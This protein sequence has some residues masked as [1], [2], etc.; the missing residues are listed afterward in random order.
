MLL[1]RMCSIFHEVHYT[2]KH[3]TEQLVIIPIQRAIHELFPPVRGTC[4][5]WTL[6][7][8]GWKSLLI[9][10]PL[11]HT[12]I[13]RLNKLIVNIYCA[14]TVGI[15]H[16]HIHSNVSGEGYV[17]SVIQWGGWLNYQSSWSTKWSNDWFE[18]LHIITLKLCTPYMSQWCF[19]MFFWNV[20][21]RIVNVGVI[22]SM[23][24][25]DFPRHF[26]ALIYLIPKPIALFN[27]SILFWV[28]NHLAWVAIG[29][30]HSIAYKLIISTTNFCDH[31]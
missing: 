14:A 27:F 19:L 5:N 31:Q 6:P 12:L 24:F 13:V 10:Q 28:W 30:P 2:A 1:A 26:H 25:N 18:Q 15:L 9:T 20:Q 3:V 23:V 11:T 4:L 17:I 21:I 16:A 22:C 29:I 8:S 7:D